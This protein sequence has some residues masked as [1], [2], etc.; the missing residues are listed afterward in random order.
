MKVLISYSVCFYCLPSTKKVHSAK[1]A[2]DLLLRSRRIMWD[3]SYDLESPEKVIICLLFVIL[4]FV[5]A[6]CLYFVCIFLYVCVCI[7]MSLYTLIFVF[8]IC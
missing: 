5:F 7:C 8:C 6:I 4:L 2:M 3:L 1:E